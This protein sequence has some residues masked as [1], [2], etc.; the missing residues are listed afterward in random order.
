LRITKIKR[1]TRQTKNIQKSI[2]EQCFVQTL[3]VTEILILVIGWY[4]ANLT[5]RFIKILLLVILSLRQQTLAASKLVDIWLNVFSLYDVPFDIFFLC[6][7]TRWPVK[8]F[9]GVL[10]HCNR[11]GRIIV[12]NCTCWLELNVSHDFGFLS[13]YWHV[14]NIVPSESQSFLLRLCPIV[15]LI[16]AFLVWSA[17]LLLIY[18]FLH[19]F[20]PLL[21]GFFIFVIAFVNKIHLVLLDF[22]LLLIDLLGCFLLRL[23]WYQPWFPGIVFLWLMGWFLAK[24]FGPFELELLVLQPHLVQDI[25]WYFLP[26]ALKLLSNLCVFPLSL[27][28]FLDFIS[29]HDHLASERMIENDKIGFFMLK[30]LIL[31]E[32]E[33]LP[34]QIIGHSQSCQ[35]VPLVNPQSSIVFD[36]EC[37]VNFRKLISKLCLAERR[38]WNVRWLIN[39]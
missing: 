27:E 34:L 20:S 22:L 9:V 39:V 5:Y 19:F 12:S 23:V 8:S 36:D 31:L 17:F 30:V 3:R 18:K 26:L 10:F 7:L 1:A 33:D 6:L 38:L 4:S 13:Y 37:V 2:H 29:G 28:L 25:L 21:L 11:S 35:L 14:I 24:H 16:Q 32:I 15:I